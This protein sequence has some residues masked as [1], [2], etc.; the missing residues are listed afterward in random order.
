MIKIHKYFLISLFIYIACSISIYSQQITTESYPEK[1]LKIIS[2]D[3]KNRTLEE[4]LFE[5]SKLA[6]IKFNYN[7]TRINTD[8]KLSIRML[9]K[10]VIDILQYIFELTQTEL[11]VI[12]DEEFLI[13]PSENRNDLV[14]EIHGK[15]IDR[16]TGRPLPGTNI[17]ILETETGASTNEL[18]EFWITDF[19]VG[20]FTLR[21]SYI[22]FK[23]IFKPDVI[24]K[25]N[26]KSFINIELE[27]TSILSDEIVVEGNYFSETEL[28]PTSAASF[29]TEEIRR[30]ATLGGDVTRIINGLPSLSND[31]EANHIV[32]RGGSTIENSF[33][34]DNIQIP[35]INHIPFPGTTGGLFSIL[36]ID[37]VENVDM[38]TGGFSSKFGD[39][40]SSVMNIKYREGN[41]KEV[42]TQIDLSFM[43]INGQIEGPIDNGSGSWMFSAR[44]SFIDLIR[45]FTKEDINLI[46]F[47]E[48]QGK[49]VYDISDKHQVSL[50]NIFSSDRYSTSKEISTHNYLYWWGDFSTIQNVLGI[51]WKYLWGAIGY[52]NT[53]VSYILRDSE[54]NQ[55]LTEDNSISTILNSTDN[56]FRL[57]NEN[58]IKINNEN[59]IEFGIEGEYVN[60]H[61]DNYFKEY[62]DYF[63]NIVPTR[64][65]DK[66][67]YAG[68]LGSFLNYEWIPFA[69]LKIISGL[70]TDYYSFN[71]NFHI[72]P[73]F[74][75]TFQLN[76][77]IS[78]T[79]SAGVFYQNLPLYF[80][81]S[82]PNTQQLQDPVAYH[83]ILGFN[84][85]LSEDTKL[86]VEIYTKDYKQIPLDSKQPSLYL[87][88]EP[89]Q[90]YLFLN[91]ENIESSGV[92]NSKG[93][94]IML[95]KKMSD[96]FCGIISAAFFK[97]KY[98]DPNGIW[99]DR[100]VDNQLLLAIEGGYKP[101]ENWEFGIRWNYAGGIPYTPFNL[102]QS[103]TNQHGVYDAENIMSKR[104]P[105]Y[106]NFSVRIDKRFYFSGSNLI[107]YISIW[108]LFDRDNK[109]LHGWARDQ[110]VAVTY[111]QMSRI[112]VL[113][114][115]FEF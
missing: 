114:I 109:S 47:N 12:S 111:S 13:A 89:F 86:S 19:P 71:K 104:L 34:V 96:N 100:I 73:R 32:A 61:S 7:H 25:S 64:E 112:V 106:Q 105:A 62:V 35:N 46:S 53:T 80:S 85:I 48:V 30:A 11:V 6:S 22:G 58:F 108:N 87:L 3:I 17:F 1:L 115:E 10:P 50:L 52:S 27:E 41:R 65:I 8:Q 102:A 28:Q 45:E 36:N 42:D 31:N 82:Y 21:V 95:Q 15:V 56:E 113:G 83:M 77:K 14:G 68:K 60:S 63:Q 70:R 9:N 18:G 26:R 16:D 20:S 4:L 57:R 93:I 81:A 23:T 107:T 29:S 66:Q 97:C 79:G 99:R 101:D 55:Y 88:D 38:Y 84:Y 94:E 51:S 49:I 44:H 24:V 59:K 76:E 37:F 91:H 33:Y 98:R 43:G 74:S 69:E 72:S 90:E 54:T 40:L 92:A 67:Y 39:R 110:N 75:F 103:T 2:I 5:I 78:F